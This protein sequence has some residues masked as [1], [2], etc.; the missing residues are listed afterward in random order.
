MHV[1]IRV[2]GG[3]TRGFGHLVRTSTVANR[4]VDRGHR[5]T[6]LTH[7][8]DAARSVYADGIPITE[9][10]RDDE[11]EATLERID[12]TGADVLVSDLPDTSIEDQRRFTESDAV[13]VVVRDDVG[14]TVCCDVLLNSHI[15]AAADAYDWIGDEP[16]WCVGGE[17]NIVNEEIR[18]VAAR[19]PRWRHPPE[20]ALV[21]MGGSDVRGTTP[22][23]LRAFADFELALDVVVGPGFDDETVAAI[24][25]ARRTVTPTVDVHRDPDD[26]GELMYRA[27]FAVTALGLTA[28]ELLA[29]G[30]PIVGTPQAADQEPKAETLRE[31]AV[32]IV[33]AADATVSQINEAITTMMS[34]ES[35]RRRFQRRGRELVSV[36]GV[37][38]FV[39]CL[40]R[41]AG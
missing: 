19:E 4:L 15:Y 16:V 10:R 24:E 37:D 35:S 20:R 5:V 17:F 3:P 34:D 23:V 31:E 21:T 9:L 12:E 41:L 26:F 8:P 14:G 1:L 28:Y 30:T 32:A 40:E 39:S 27:D 22:D 2:D 11:V 6:C 25:E 7:T 38:R 36:D 13:F 18:A 33:L 29:V